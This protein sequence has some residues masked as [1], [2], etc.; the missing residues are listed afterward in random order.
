M[1]LAE[2]SRSLELIHS[3]YLIR[4]YISSENNSFQKFNFSFFSHLNALGSKFDLEVKYVKV[5]IGS[6]FE[7]T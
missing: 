7:Q 5:S 2:K 3:H 1:T 4:L 6:L